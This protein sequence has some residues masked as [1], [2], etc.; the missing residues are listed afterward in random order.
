MTN[1][2]T[3]GMMYIHVLERGYGSIVR[4]MLSRIEALAYRVATAHHASRLGSML[5]RRSNTPRWKH[6]QIVLDLWNWIYRQIDRSLE[7][8]QDLSTVGVTAVLP[9]VTPGEDRKRA[10]HECHGTITIDSQREWCP[11]ARSRE[12]NNKETS[13]LR[14]RYSRWCGRIWVESRWHPPISRRAFH[15]RCS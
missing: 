9:D 7:A 5:T 10:A 1:K 2:P 12:R 8:F 4:P 14:N 11:R 13:S 6:R 3:T 15:H